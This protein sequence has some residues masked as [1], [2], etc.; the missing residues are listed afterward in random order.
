MPDELRTAVT[1]SFTT[2]QWLTMVIALV[3]T[4]WSFKFRQSPSLVSDKRKQ[5]LC[6]LAAICLIPLWIL[7]AGLH[8][9][10]DIHFLGLTTLTLLLGWRLAAY[11]AL[12]TL[13]LL[14][15]H[16]E[17]PLAYIGLHALAS[18]AL[19]VLISQTV[20][21]L[22]LRH[23]P[24]NYFIYVFV[25]GFFAGGISMLA[26]HLFTA[27]YFLVTGDYSTD[28]IWQDFLSLWPLPIFPEALLN[29][30]S[31]ALLAIYKPHWLSQSDQDQWR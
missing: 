28:I 24:S 2:W 31:I 18:I 7:K 13:I 30:M 23:C 14:A 12:A 20:Y 26:R 27:S 15:C 8:P 25:C 1:H 3:L 9:G 11:S 10:L 6:L 16:G 29:G 22:Y 19:P 4:L 21:S 17:Q 5:H